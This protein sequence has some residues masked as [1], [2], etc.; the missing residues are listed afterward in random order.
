MGTTVAPT[1]VI[2][3]VG[4][5]ENKLYSIIEN[6]YGLAHR[7]KLVTSWKRYLHDYLVICDERIYKVDNLFEIL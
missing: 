1:Y 7:S 3:V 4:Y 2:L 5:L 6:K